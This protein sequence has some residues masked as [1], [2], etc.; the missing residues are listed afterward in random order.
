MSI[1]NKISAALDSIK[2]DFFLTTAMI[3]A[4]FLLCKGQ[5]DIYSDRGHVQWPLISSNS[6]W[7]EI[8]HHAKRLAIHGD[9]SMGCSM[10]WCVLM[11]GCVG[12]GK[13][14]AGLIG[15]WRG[16]QA[17][18]VKSLFITADCLSVTGRVT[19]H[20]TCTAL[21]PQLVFH[22]FPSGHN[23]VPAS[24]DGWGAWALQ[25]SGDNWDSWRWRVRREACNGLA[26]AKRHV[27]A[28]DLPRNVLSIS[29]RISF[30]L[31]KL[32]LF[33]GNSTEWHIQLSERRQTALKQTR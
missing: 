5:W 6:L 15:A 11:C 28:S 25:H 27:Q 1:N 12:F 30:I 17:G 13:S 10:I 33:R 31:H 20:R 19:M 8:A 21:Y 32:L 23:G 18:C 22:R 4:E 29:Q 16:S 2:T 26:A 24:V 9:L 7:T 14:G 3:E